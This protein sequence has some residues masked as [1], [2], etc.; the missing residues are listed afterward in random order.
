MQDSLE[1]KLVSDFTF[2]WSDKLSLQPIGKRD[3]EEIVAARSI[4]GWWGRNSGWCPAAVRQ[5]RSLIYKQKSMG[6]RLS[7]SSMDMVNFILWVEWATP[8]QLEWNF[9]YKLAIR[10]YMCSLPQVLYQYGRHGEWDA[11][12]NPIILN[13]VERLILLG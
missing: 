13:L 7:A 4:L 5:H 9:A 11:S 6:R 12:L 3:D 2:I 10:T 8:A 1:G